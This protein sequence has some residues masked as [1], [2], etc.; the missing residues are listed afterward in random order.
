VIGERERERRD[1]FGGWRGRCVPEEKVRRRH[2]KEEGKGDEMS[3]GGETR[4]R[5]VTSA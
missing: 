5:K 4:K 3:R 1:C 2:Q